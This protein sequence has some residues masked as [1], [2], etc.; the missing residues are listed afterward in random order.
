[1]QLAYRK[2][3]PESGQV[4]AVLAA[5]PG[6]NGTACDVAPLGRYLDK[7][8][9]AVYSLSMR[10]QHGDLTAASRRS[11]GDVESEQR[12]ESDFFEFTE[13]IHR[14]H[15]RTPLLL[16]GQSMGALTAL[17][18][19]AKE[20]QD[21]SARPRGVILHSPAVAMM[22]TWP[23]VRIFVDGM[24]AVYP[25][26][27]LFAISLIPGDEPALTNNAKFDLYWGES[28]DRVEPGFTWSFFDESLKLGARAR[29]GA[30]QLHRPVLMLTGDQDPIGPAGVGQGA[31]AR[32][33]RTFP[34]REKQRRRFPDGYHDLLHDSNAE[35]AV[36]CIGD[37]VD[38]ILRE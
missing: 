29:M 27:L 20:A 36:R 1:V 37:W 2:W 21:G 25:H 26:R 23:V 14:R 13:W 18:V 34:T 33:L 4:R 12:W 19:S 31:F 17:L 7:R 11:K 6:W 35:E 38:E 28:V 30:A 3:E 15:P 8:G 22:Y 24:R 5:A 9:I 10:G 32:L 16:Y